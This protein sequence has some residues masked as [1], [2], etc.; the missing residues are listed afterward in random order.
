MK[1]TRT[2]IDFS[3]LLK[4]PVIWLL[5]A[6]FMRNVSIYYD[7]KE[8]SWAR[9]VVGITGMIYDGWFYPDPGQL[10]SYRIRE[11]IYLQ[12]QK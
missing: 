6:M 3:P 2:A 5:Q 9:K 7:Q 1:A 12:E 8:R 4:M 10:I 11:N